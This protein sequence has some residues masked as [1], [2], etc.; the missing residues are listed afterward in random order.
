MALTHLANKIT[1]AIDLNEITAG[2]FLDLSKAFDTVDHEILLAKLEHYGISGSPLK[3]I[4]NYFLNRKQFMQFNETC[5]SKQ[6]N[7][8]RPSGIY[9]RLFVIVLLQSHESPVLNRHAQ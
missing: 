6:N 7:L 9:F 3:W 5:S 1:S 4:K 2:V 8:R